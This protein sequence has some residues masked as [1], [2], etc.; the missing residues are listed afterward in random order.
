M[1]YIGVS[2]EQEHVIV[3]VSTLKRTIYQK[4]NL[5]LAKQFNR[6]FRVYE[7]NRFLY[8]SMNENR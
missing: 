4:V 2:I 7:I 8:K 6:K 5:P 1:I 3:Q